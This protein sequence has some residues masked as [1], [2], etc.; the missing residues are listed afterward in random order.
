VLSHLA[1]AEAPADGLEHRSWRVDGH[2]ALARFVVKPNAKWF[3]GHFPGHPVLPGVAQLISLVARP[4]RRAWPALQDV[5]AVPRVRFLEP[6]GPH[7]VLDV[8]LT[9][10]GARVTFLI[11][12]THTPVAKGTIAFRQHGEEGNA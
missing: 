7:D 5:S 12:R 4:A 2:Q 3:E 10:A 9:R 6:V 11:S 8:T 1:A